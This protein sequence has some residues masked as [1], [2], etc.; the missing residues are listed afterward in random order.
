MIECPSCGRKVSREAPACPGCGQPMNEGRMEPKSGA[1]GFM[2]RRRNTLGLVLGIAAILLV[3]WL[4]TWAN[5]HTPE[6]PAAN[7][8]VGQTSKTP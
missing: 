5:R 4:I 2:D 7:I 1:R 8:P 3:A 6:P